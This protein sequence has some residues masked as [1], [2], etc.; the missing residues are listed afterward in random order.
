MTTGRWAGSMK[1]ECGLHVL[2]HGLVEVDPTQLVDPL[3]RP[4]DPELGAVTLKSLCAW[5]SGVVFKL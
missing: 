2:E 1:K 5:A 3:R 4:P